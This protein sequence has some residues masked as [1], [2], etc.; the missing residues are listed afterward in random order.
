MTTVYNI[1]CNFS[2]PS[3]FHAVNVVDKRHGDVTLIRPLREI[4]EKEIALVNRYFLSFSNCLEIEEV[5]RKGSD[6]NFENNNCE[7]VDKHFTLYK[8]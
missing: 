4:S 6:S 2:G 1:T 8:C 5:G 7:Y 3:V